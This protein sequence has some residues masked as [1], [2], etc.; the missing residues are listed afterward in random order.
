M[1][2]R[3]T[4]TPTSSPTLECPPARRHIPNTDLPPNLKPQCEQIAGRRVNQGASCVD[5][6]LGWLFVIWSLFPFRHVQIKDRDDGSDR[7]RHSQLAER[8]RDLG[9]C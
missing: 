9:S 6:A 1:G 3:G 2:G 8:H 5:V 4:T 7:S